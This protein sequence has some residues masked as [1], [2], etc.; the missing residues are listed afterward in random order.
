MP[1]ECKVCNSEKRDYIEQLILQG[2][3][4]LAVSTTLKDMNEDISHASINRHKTKHMP[5]NVEKIKEVS[6]EKNNRKYNRDDSKN[7]FVINTSS[8]FNEIE[9]D[10]NNLSYE[11]SAKN[12]IETSLMLNKIAKNQCAIVL[13]LQ[14]KYMNGEC[15]YPHEQIA[16]LDKIQSLII[17][18]E[19][20][21][22]KSYEYMKEIEN[23]RMKLFKNENRHLDSELEIKKWFKNRPYV[24]G[25][26]FNLLKHLNYDLEAVLDSVNEMY[27]PNLDDNIH[28]E[29]YRS[30]EHNK[31]MDILYQLYD[32]SESNNIDKIK[33]IT[34]ILINGDYEKAYKELA[35]IFNKL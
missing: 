9:H 13:E 23:K 35:D 20:F 1:I 2:H 22:N 3:S 18:H 21:Q 34:N 15:K 27:Y 5:D 14:E 16:G 28:I 31:D 25:Y 4:N 33:E 32:L 11:E 10:I 26:I 7:S 24:K 29:K 6:H 19:S 30:V 12:F 8:I 17:K